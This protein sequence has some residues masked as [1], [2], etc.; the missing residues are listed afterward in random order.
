MKTYLGVSVWLLSE[1]V[2]RLGC[3]LIISWQIWWFHLWHLL[4]PIHFVWVMC[5]WHL[6]TCFQQVRFQKNYCK[7]HLDL[8]RCTFFLA[9][10]TVPV[11]KWLTFPLHLQPFS[12]K[13]QTMIGSGI[14]CMEMRQPHLPVSALLWPDSL[15][16]PAVR[17]IVWWQK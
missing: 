6:S 7:S 14:S 3:W 16:N 13:V 1:V 10:E 17:K 11:R 15:L 2:G 4:L 12:G 5:C 9:K 8:D